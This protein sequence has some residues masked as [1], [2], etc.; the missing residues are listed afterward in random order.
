MSKD[1]GTG[2]WTEFL[3]ALDCLNNQ[4]IYLG[5]LSPV[6]FDQIYKMMG[7]T[8][9][10]NESVTQKQVSFESRALITVEEI[11]SMTEVKSE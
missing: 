6:E 5:E 4:K 7:I 1:F 9:D 11:L 2:L 8:L 3:K 10:S